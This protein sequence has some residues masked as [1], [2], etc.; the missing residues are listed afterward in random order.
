VAVLLLVGRDAGGVA[1]EVFERLEGE[2][3]EVPHLRQ[4][5]DDAHAAQGVVDPPVAV[6]APRLSLEGDRGPV[7]GRAGLDQLEG[8]LGEPDRLAV[9]GGRE[10]LVPPRAA[11]EAG[12]VRAEEGRG[13]GAL[14]AGPG[15]LPDP[16]ERGPGPVREARQGGV[17]VIVGCGR[18]GQDAHADREVVEEA[19]DGETPR[20]VPVEGGVEPPQ[21]GRPRAPPGTWPRSGR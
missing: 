3:H 16:P 19:R 10:G 20:A 17:E 6:L 12:E 14:E 5:R 13:H 1:L 11:L 18:V 15:L 2:H 9:Q 4:E 7:R 8:A 21:R